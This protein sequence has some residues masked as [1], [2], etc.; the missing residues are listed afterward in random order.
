MG[1]DQKRSA[2]EARNVKPQ[3]I[4]TS[5]NYKLKQDV[6]VLVCRQS[7]FRSSGWIR[8]WIWIAHKYGWISYQRESPDEHR[9]FIQN[10]QTPLGYRLHFIEFGSTLSGTF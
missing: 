7:E 8:L 5:L 9:V 2:C 4:H 6:L 3:G 10:A 1:R